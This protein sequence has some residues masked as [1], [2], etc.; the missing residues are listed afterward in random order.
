MKSV[1]AFFAGV[2]AGLVSVLAF[3]LGRK[4]YG[5]GEPAGEPGKNISDA[6][7]EAGRAERLNSEAGRINSELA[8]LSERGSE[9]LEEIRKQKLPE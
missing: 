5:N 6:K 9:I 2:I 7:D 1:K 8:E 3:L 4:L